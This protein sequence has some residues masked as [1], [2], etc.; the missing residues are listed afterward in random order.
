MS[1]IST[2]VL[3]TSRG[4]PAPGIQVSLEQ[5]NPVAPGTDLSAS[6]P[7]ALAL[8]DAEGRINPLLA[9]DAVTPGAY[10]L[11]FHTGPYFAAQNLPTLYPEIT[12]TFTVREDEQNY[13]IPLLLTPHSYTT[14]RGT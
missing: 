4:R 12:I 1:G 8:T 10:R 2:H 13:H 14:Y 3:D 5:L 9:P 6:R 7:L 11:T